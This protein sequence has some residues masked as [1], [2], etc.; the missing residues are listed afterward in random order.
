MGTTDLSDKFQK[1][2]IRNIRIG[3]M[4]NL[5]VTRQTACLVINPITVDSFAAL[6]K[7]HAGGSGV[8][9]YDGPT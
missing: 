7:M 1:I 8:R 9:L 6:F 2:I 4:Y 5:N 3:Y